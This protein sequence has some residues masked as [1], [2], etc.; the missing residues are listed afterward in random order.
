MARST[1]TSTTSGLIVDT[2]ADLN[3]IMVKND[4]PGILD[5]A[6]EPP[7]TSTAPTVSS[8]VKSAT[9]Q[10]GDYCETPPGAFGRLY[11]TFRTAGTAY[12]TTFNQKL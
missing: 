10:S 3:G 12:V 6:L 7:G 5:I 2:S 4:G 11:G 9:L 1:Y 8:T